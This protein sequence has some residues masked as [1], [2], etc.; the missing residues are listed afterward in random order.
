MSQKLKL[1]PYYRFTE[2]KGDYDA[3]AFIDGPNHYSAS[4]VNTGLTGHYIYKRGTIH[5]NYGYDL[6]KEIT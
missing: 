1:S 6:T 3:D 4:L 5:F 2:F